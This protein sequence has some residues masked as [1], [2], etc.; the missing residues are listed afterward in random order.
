MPVPPQWRLLAA[1]FLTLF[2][3][4]TATPATQPS[5]TWSRESNGLRARLA[6]RRSHV[7]NGTGIVVTHL[8]LN[9]VSDIGNPMLVTLRGQGMKFSVT[10]ADG[11]T[12]PMSGGAFSGFDSCPPELILPH[13]SSIRFRIGPRG[14]GIPGEQAALVDLGPS[15]GWALAW[16][17]WA[18]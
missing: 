8:E 15:F 9:N 11:R 10:D 2:A 6:M 12:V 14:W 3:T 13:D 4:A 16:S 1:L 18:R 17:C 7:S 5:D